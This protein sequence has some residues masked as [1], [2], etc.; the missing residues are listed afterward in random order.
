V[1]PQVVWQAGKLVALSGAHTLLAATAGPLV[2]L[3]QHL[4]LQVGG[5]QGSE[6]E[7]VAADATPALVFV[8]VRDVERYVQE[9]RLC[10]AAV[11]TR[12]AL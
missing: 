4:G 2:L 12:R 8:S 9:R 7:H 1:Q 6:L 10:N 3:I 5:Q 11:A